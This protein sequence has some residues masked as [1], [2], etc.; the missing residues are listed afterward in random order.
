MFFIIRD[1]EYLPAG[2]TTFAQF[3]AE[4]FGGHRAT[5]ADWGTHLSTLFP[6]V[7]LK[8]YLEIRGCDAGSHG[9]I[10]GLGPLTA[11]ILYDS[12]AREAATELTA[13]LDFGQRLELARD[14]TRSG[15][16]AKTASGTAVVEL[17]RE[18]VAIAKAGLANVSAADLHF[19]E[20]LEAI[21]HS[22]RSQADD[23]IEVW[24]R[25]ASTEARIAAL[26]YPG[27]SPYR[28]SA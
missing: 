14:V 12:G 19:I 20:P 6:E 10:A 24:N 11:G 9:V 2:G 5:M 1:G 4:G 17:T 3:L 13:D 8:T 21:A 15:L 16:A 23:M 28:K 26:A 18:L 27:L 7:R 22:G 25:E